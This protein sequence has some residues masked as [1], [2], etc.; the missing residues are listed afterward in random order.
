MIAGG[1]EC[2]G[3]KMV[4][5]I[6][7]D[8]GNIIE[9][10]VIPTEKPGTTLTH[11]YDWFRVRNIDCL[12]IGCFGP[13]CMDRSDKRY[14]Y[15]TNTPK[16]GWQDVNVVARFKGLDVPIGFD[17][18]V[19]GAALGEL[20]YGAG[21]GLKSLVYITI[22]TGIGIGVIADGRI[23]HGMMHPEGGHILLP[24]HRDDVSY[25]SCCPFHDSC[26]EGLASGPAL[27]KR[28]GAKG[29]N[30]GDNKDAWD[31]EAW[32]IAQACINYLMI[33]SPER[34]ILGGGVMHREELL[35]LIRENFCNMLGEYIQTERVRDIDGYIVKSSLEDR[36]GILGAIQLGINEMK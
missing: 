14:G 24:R 31:M 3:T 28:W 36:Q 32:Y 17:T 35:P 12:G 8:K 22:G 20:N 30:I 7:D 29:A 5:A 10:T 11:M 19:N 26:F 23:L 21:K 1:I 2:G 13:I 15:I 25:K 9:S 16:A 34:I 27:E 6:G 18:D 33:L 4:C